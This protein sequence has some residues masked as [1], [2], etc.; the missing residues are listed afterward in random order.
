MT[1]AN[2][3]NSRAEAKTKAVDMVRREEKAM[4][5]GRRQAMK[6][7]EDFYKAYLKKVEENGSNLE[8]MDLLDMAIKAD[9]QLAPR[10]Q[11]AQLRFF[12]S[13]YEGAK[14]DAKTWV[15]MMK[16]ECK[17]K[18]E[19]NNTQMQSLLFHCYLEENNLQAANLILDRDFTKES[20]MYIKHKKE[21]EEAKINKKK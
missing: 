14:A 10:G 5:M 20:E 6:E 4:A 3:V 8:K 2:K 21:F 19:V 15:K 16:K 7:G 11:R 1:A 12:M 17:N 18:R 9:D 13:D